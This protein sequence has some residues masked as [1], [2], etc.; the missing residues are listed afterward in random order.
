MTGSS[1]SNLNPDEVDPSVSPTAVLD[2]R[3][4]DP[5]NT[6]AEDDPFLHLH[7][8]STTAGVGSGDYVAI[9]G[10]AIA[11]ILLGLGSAFVLFDSLIF[12]I[13]PL[14]GVIT[15]AFAW[16]Q[17]SKSNGTQTGR[18]IVVVG[19]LLALGFGG[20]FSVRKVYAAFQNQADE[21]QIVSQVNKLGELLRDGRYNDAYLLFD[22]DFKRKY[23]LEEFQNNWKRFSANPYLGSVRS[24]DW[25]QLLNFE[26]NPVD[27]S[28]QATGMML[29]YAKPSSPI[30]I[31]MSF[32]KVEDTW[33]V[34]QL[35]E[36]F[37][38]EPKKTVPA[39]MGPPKPK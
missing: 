12:L 14:L 21:H 33:L 7:K 11:C 10:T 31:H 9:N 20:F 30:R 4:R 36:L 35:Q 24:I 13:I 8:M 2:G 32:R 38:Q 37:A 19:L 25:N 29:L 3:S 5:K 28:Q 6:S 34:D 1:G 27:N 18:E 15:G 26:T 22:D 16:K 17:I 39:V 23:P